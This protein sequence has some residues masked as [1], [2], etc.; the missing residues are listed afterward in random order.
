MKVLRTTS[1]RK[2]ELVVG[3]GEGEAPILGSSQ[4]SLQSPAEGVADRGTR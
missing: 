3:W 1:R 2:L 4:R